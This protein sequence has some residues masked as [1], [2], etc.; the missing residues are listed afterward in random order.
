MELD[1]RSLAE[2]ERC[3]DELLGALGLAWDEPADPRV[4]ALAA[5]QPLYP[6]YHRI[7]HK[8]QLAYRTL[9]GERRL[10]LGSYDAVVR[11]VVADRGTDSPRWLVSVLVSAVGRRRAE[12]DLLAAGASADALRWVRFQAAATAV[13]VRASS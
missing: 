7:G 10:V 11:A 13:A 3:L 12:A 4:E 6:Q 9:D 1:A 2:Q 8:R 5:R